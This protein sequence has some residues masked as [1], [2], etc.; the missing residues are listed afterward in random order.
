MRDS[1]LLQWSTSQVVDQGIHVDEEQNMFYHGRNPQIR[2]LICPIED[3]EIAPLRMMYPE[4]F[5]DQD[6]TQGR[7]KSN[8]LPRTSNTVSNTEEVV[9]EYVA[10]L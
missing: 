10:R 1:D 6:C 3:A 4:P 2:Q 7:R 8:Q 9:P 5:S